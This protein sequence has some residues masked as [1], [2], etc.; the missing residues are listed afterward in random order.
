MGSLHGGVRKAAAHYSM[1]S[2]SHSW[3]RTDFARFPTFWS[4][5]STSRRRAGPHSWDW[6]EQA[7]S[8]GAVSGC[9]LAAGR[10]GPYIHRGYGA[11][12][13]GQRR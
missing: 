7:Q 4:S 11:S 3:W 2:G 8:W 12:E 9:E 6:A 1:T 5:H 10:R 13:G